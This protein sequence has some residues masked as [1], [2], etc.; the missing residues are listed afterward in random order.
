MSEECLIREDKEEGL[1]R[2]EEG[3]E[4]CFKEE[5]E[6]EGPASA[7]V[8]ARSLGCSF[9]VGMRGGLGL[10]LWLDR[11]VRIK[12]TLLTNFGLPPAKEKS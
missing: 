3:K 12:P 11:R 6:E 5:W 1:F 10:G 7:V 8:F 9:L 2:E 4:V